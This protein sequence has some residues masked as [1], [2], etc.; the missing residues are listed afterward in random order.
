MDFETI[1]NDLLA[2]LNSVVFTILSKLGEVLLIAG[3]YINENALK[4]A[5]DSLGVWGVMTWSKI[6]IFFS[7]R[8]KQ[9][10]KKYPAIQL[11]N[12]YSWYFICLIHS[13]IINTRIEP[14]ENHWITIA[15]LY[16]LTGNQRLNDNYVFEEHMNLLPCVDYI[17]NDLKNEDLLLHMNEWIDATQNLFEDDGLKEVIILLK[18]GKQYVYRICRK[19]MSHLQSILFE[20]SGM[21]FLSIEYSYPGINKPIFIDVDKHAYF[22][23]NEILSP[24][25]I[26]RFFDYNIGLDKDVFR[27]EYVLKIMDNNL[28]IFELKSDQYILLQT[29]SYAIKNIQ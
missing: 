24:A 25:F 11:I 7:T 17:S 29:N 9:L 23:D 1:F 21:R 28:N 2:V 14:K 16:R 26:K 5:K 10:E 3:N 6:K 15:P 12:E 22:I 13:I 8:K 4:P 19:G 27:S 20:P 18:F